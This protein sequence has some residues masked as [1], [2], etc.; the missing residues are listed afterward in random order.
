MRI[1]ISAIGK[2]KSGPENHLY[3]DYTKRLPWKVTCSEHVA[4]AQSPTQR[5]ERESQLLLESCKGYDKL[6]ALDETGK[7]YSSSEFAKQIEGWQQQGASSLAFMIGGSDG[8][9]QDALSKA[10][11]IWSF[12]RVTWPHMLVRALLAEQLYR[13]HS[14]ITNHP[15]HRE[16]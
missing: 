5:I 9:S 16:G 3:Q 15:Y 10:D 11:C 7:L 1:L 14:I 13:A 12:G 4:K 2:A 6:I 8:L